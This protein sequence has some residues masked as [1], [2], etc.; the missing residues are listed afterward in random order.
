MDPY[1]RRIL[2]LVYSK[3]YVISPFNLIITLGNTS[4]DAMTQ[5]ADTCLNGKVIAT[6][7]EELEPN[8]LRKRKEEAAG[9]MFGNNN[10]FIKK[11]K[12][13]DNA[14]KGIIRRRSSA[15]MGRQ[16]AFSFFKILKINELSL[17]LEPIFT[18][19]CKYKRIMKLYINT[20]F[21]TNTPMFVK[22][23]RDVILFY[24]CF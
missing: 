24:T 20:Y 21:K 18:N 3:Y 6:N 22:Y 5:G 14:N 4:M 12:K 9:G 13:N 2:S 11:E 7:L 8:N 15:F 1:D 23:F 16:N 17:G 10:Y 19:L